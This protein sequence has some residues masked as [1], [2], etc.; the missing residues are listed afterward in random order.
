MH[1]FATRDSTGCILI[2]S[3]YKCTAAKCLCHFAVK[4]MTCSKYV[5]IC[6]GTSVSN[7]RFWLDWTVNSYCEFLSMWRSTDLQFLPIYHKQIAC[8]CQLDP[9]Q[10]QTNS[11][12]AADHA[13]Y[14]HFHAPQSLWTMYS[15]RPGPRFCNINFKGN[16]ITSSMRTSQ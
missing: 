15:F 9:I 11:R 1:L 12:L 16:E 14:H 7:L 2:I 10:L 6:G 5:T 8:H 4:L 13:F 3:L